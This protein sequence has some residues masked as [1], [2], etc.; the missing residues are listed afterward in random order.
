MPGSQAS[1]R[2]EP[3]GERDQQLSP[4]AVFD[5]LSNGRR[6]YA[7]SY[8][9]AAG[10][11][12]TVRN[13]SRDIAAWE[14][15][16][17]PAEVTPRQRKRVYTALHQTHLLRLDEFGVVEYDRNRGIVG[18][19]D[20]L[21]TLQ[22][23]LVP[24]APARTVPRSIHAIGLGGIGLGVGTLLDL[25]LLG[26]LPTGLGA[27]VVGTA[28][29]ASAVFASSRHGSEGSYLPADISR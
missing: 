28:I 15:G 3:E 10:E 4:D 26:P 20:G 17:E 24:E 9:L 14:N 22:P 6:R 25:P 13:L 7:L 27:L 18:P 16:V 29:L 1:V 12:V 19:A 5:I 8:L 2:S 11:P 21:T 23:L